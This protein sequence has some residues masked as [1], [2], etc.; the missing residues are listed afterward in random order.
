MAEITKRASLK[1]R[2][3]IEKKKM[4]LIFIKLSDD[5]FKNT[6]NWIS[7]ISIRPNS[8]IYI[9]YCFAVGHGSKK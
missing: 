2:P 5:L 9:S 6:R 8:Y 1:I 3:K 4:A 7:D